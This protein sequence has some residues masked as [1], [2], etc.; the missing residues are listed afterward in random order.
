METNLEKAKRQLRDNA[1]IAGVILPED[2]FIMKMLDLAVTPDKTPIIYQ[3][4]YT[5]PDFTVG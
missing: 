4:D 3:A 5:D 1:A 2:G